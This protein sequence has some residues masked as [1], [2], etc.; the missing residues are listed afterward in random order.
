MQEMAPSTESVA[1]FAPVASKVFEELVKMDQE[2]IRVMLID[3]HQIMREGLASLLEKF[4]ELEVVAQSSSLSESLDLIAQE[5][6][7]IIITDLTMNGVSPFEMSNEINKLGRRIHIL[8]L[9]SAVTDNNLERGLEAGAAGFISKSES[10][11]GILSALRTVHE[12]RKYFSEDIKKRLISRYSFDPSQGAYSP[13]RSL[14]SP[15]EVEV[16]C[17]VA[18]GMKAKNIG[19][20]LHITAKTVERH[21]SNIM[22]KLSLHSQV[23]LATYAIREGYIVP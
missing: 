21:K 15:R 1:K 17:C 14:L 6:P 2:T 22:A 20:S 23:D 9:V 12:G 19:K 4:D 8:Y 18:K 3:D 13:R 11:S 5:E 7:E 10:I 16:L